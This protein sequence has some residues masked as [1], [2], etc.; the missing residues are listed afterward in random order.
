MCSLTHKGVPRGSQDPLFLHVISAQCLSG[1]A[2]ELVSTSLATSAAQ[3]ACSGLAREGSKPGVIGIDEAERKYGCLLFTVIEFTL[4][5]QRY[6]A[7]AS[8]DPRNWRQCLIFDVR[9]RKEVIETSELWWPDRIGDKRN[10]DNEEYVA[11]AE[12]DDD[13][14]LPDWFKPPATNDG[15][16]RTLRHIMEEIL[17]PV[18]TRP[19]S[20][21]FRLGPHLPRRSPLPFPVC[22]LLPTPES[23]PS[24][25]PTPPRDA[26]DEDVIPLT[27]W[28]SSPPE[29]RSTFDPTF[30]KP[31][32]FRQ[33]RSEQL[34]MAH[35]IPPG[36]NQVPF[37]L[38]FQGAVLY[39]PLGQ[40]A[41]PLRPI[42]H[43]ANSIYL[44]G[45]TQHPGYVPQHDANHKILC[46]LCHHQFRGG[47]QGLSQL[48][49]HLSQTVPEFRARMRNG[50]TIQT[51]LQDLDAYNL[52]RV[53]LHCDNGFRHPNNLPTGAVD[54]P[55]LHSVPRFWWRFFGMHWTDSCRMFAVRIAENAPPYP[56]RP[57][58]VAQRMAAVENIWLVDARGFFG[59][60]LQLGRQVSQS[61]NLVVV[62]ICYMP[63]GNAGRPA[64][65]SENFCFSEEL[66]DTQRDWRALEG[67][68]GVPVVVTVLQ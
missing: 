48:R 5:M 31:V 22:R 27:P 18:Q 53:L 47:Q 12:K 37:V 51:C 15:M 7:T 52:L 29:V 25:L 13:K 56:P 67:P 38:E 42:S 65:R 45:D 1:S 55:A 14:P 64:P 20:P 59:F 17:T 21:E 41:N 34:I 36:R 50:P 32:L 43:P 28:N 35:R 30:R 66:A 9:G 40:M 23:C 61:V 16:Y 2:W 4:L 11:P 68:L 33:T 49:Q 44:P 19:V 24:L 39:R 3:E 26:S 54:M 62:I 46:P 60:E 10:P 58:S 57:G 6:W 63:A 8:L